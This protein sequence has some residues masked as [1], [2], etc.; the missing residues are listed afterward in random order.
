MEKITEPARFWGRAPGAPPRVIGHRGAARPDTPGLAPSS[1]APPT[2]AERAPRAPAE[3]TLPAFEEAIAQGACAF[4]LDVRVAATGEVVVF[5]DPTLERLTEG[6]DL[7]PIAGLSAAELGRVRLPGGERIPH[8]AEVLAM[9]RPRGIGVNIELK[10]DVPDRRAAA[11]ETARLLRAWDPAHP[12]LVSSFDPWML[13]LH[14]A[15]APRIPIA[16]LV[17]R[18]NY[19]ALMLALGPALLP[20]SAVHIERT[21]ASE[22]RIASLRRRGHA[23]NVWTVND[24]EEA[25]RLSSF[26]ADGI[27]T[28]SPARI[29]AA[30]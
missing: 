28:D 4:E 27:I 21:L 24:P 12:L 5:H 17:H 26:G 9:A 8:L 10:R 14:R 7:R 25:R 3:N 20:V 30:L 18:S 22:E 11:S 13:A 23:V 15:L 1:P 16:L 29:C 6:G 2:Q 19:H